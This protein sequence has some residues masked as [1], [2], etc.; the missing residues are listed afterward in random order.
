MKQLEGVYLVPLSRFFDERTYGDVPWLIWNAHEKKEI[1][2]RAQSIIY[3]LGFFENKG[4]I[5]GMKEAV[6]F[7]HACILPEIVVEDRTY[8]AGG[9]MGVMEYPDG[10][11]D[12]VLRGEL[13]EGVTLREQ[14]ILMLMYA[15]FIRR[16]LTPGEDCSDVL[17][18]MSFESHQI[19]VRRPFIK[20]IQA[21]LFR[22][23]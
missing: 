21:S 14:M 5:A 18:N 10:S 22:T 3:P 2:K 17:K 1:E 7:Q 8:P 13:F 16:T 19:T 23:R 12:T 15:S 11:Q 6:F 9:I 20:A 4:T